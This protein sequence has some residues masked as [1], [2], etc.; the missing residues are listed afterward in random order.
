MARNQDEQ[1]QRQSPSESQPTVP[2]QQ[3]QPQGGPG[4]VPQRWDPF[5]DLRA[6]MDR[7]FDSF[8]SAFQPLSMMRPM[9]MGPMGMGG[10]DL[11]RPMM[12]GMG[13]EISPRVDIAESDESLILTA[14]LPGLEER[15]IDVTIANGVLTLKGEKRT[16]RDERKQ[17]YHLVERSH[18]TFSRSFRLPDTVD[19][20]KCDARFDKGVLTITLPKS[21]AGKQQVRHIQVTKAA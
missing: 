1:P 13:M 18:G 14:D 12:M 7:V 17:N 4:S 5:F 11:M 8:L 16:E 19:Q 20:E 3:Q 15:N 6:Q 10:L 21:E 9:G 2:A